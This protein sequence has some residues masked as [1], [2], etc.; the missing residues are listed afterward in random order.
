MV[1]IIQTLSVIPAYGRTY[2][3]DKGAERA[4]Q[5]WKAGKDF[6]I[7]TATDRWCGKY[8]NKED[9]ERSEYDLVDVFYSGFRYIT[10]KISK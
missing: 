8:I 4:L 9:A 6:I 1:K 5:D 7:T 10:I 2:D 3:D